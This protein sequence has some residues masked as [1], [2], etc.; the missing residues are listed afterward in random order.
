M[1]L[2]SDSLSKYIYKNGDNKAVFIFGKR[3]NNKSCS[4]TISVIW[5]WRCPAGLALEKWQKERRAH[6]LFC[7][8]LQPFQDSSSTSPKTFPFQGQRTHS[9]KIL[10]SVSHGLDLCEINCFSLREGIPNLNERMRWGFC[11]AWGSIPV[12]L[13]GCGTGLSYSEGGSRS[14]QTP[15]HMMCATSAHTAWKAN[16]WEKS[17]ISFNPAL[18]ASQDISPVF[19][20]GN[21]QFL[22]FEL[23][24]ETPTALP[25]NVLK[26]KR[27]PT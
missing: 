8:L 11:G 19:M 14:L 23:S 17:R 3:K 24:C 9:A 10:V 15:P 12:A 26:Y 1:F 27:H 7:P 4:I 2:L 16:S 13:I 20:L 22:G 5:S 18:R 21:T 25:S 6:A